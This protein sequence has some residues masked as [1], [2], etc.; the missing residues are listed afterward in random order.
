MPKKDFK[1]NS[2][3]LDL[4][5]AEKMLDDK[6]FKSAA[7]KIKRYIHALKVYM[8]NVDGR[9]IAFYENE[10]RL[11]KIEDIMNLMDEKEGVFIN[12]FEPNQIIGNIP[13]LLNEFKNL[14]KISDNDFNYASKVIKS[15][16][17]LYPLLEKEG[18]G[19][20]EMFYPLV[21]YFGEVLKDRLNGN[22]AIGKNSLGKETVVVQGADGKEYDP[23]YCINRILTNGHKPHAFEAAIDKQLKPNKLKLAQPAAG[24]PLNKV[25]LPGSK[26][27]GDKK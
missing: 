10:A 6:H 24:I 14:F 17:S 4:G 25:E 18:V 13:A 27:A 21:A 12:D 19:E 22:W 3:K 2:L 26:K 5:Q 8:H 16:D 1:V 7:P 15:V 9:T 23:Y 20:V 11:F